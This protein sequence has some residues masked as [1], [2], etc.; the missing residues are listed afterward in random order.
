M[1]LGRSFHSITY[2]D[3][4][5]ARSISENHLKDIRSRVTTHEGE[6][7]SGK[8]G[9]AY[10]DKYSKK[11]LGKDMGGIWNKRSV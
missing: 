3:G 2:H 7:L 1:A 10:M 4:N 5:R 9:R 8:S 11:Y 6:L